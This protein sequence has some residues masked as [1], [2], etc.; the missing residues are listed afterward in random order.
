V[1][2]EPD[3]LELVVV[4]RVVGQ[5]A[6]PASVFMAHTKPVRCATYYSRVD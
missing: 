5:Q 3:A 4:E 2:D 6:A 1:G